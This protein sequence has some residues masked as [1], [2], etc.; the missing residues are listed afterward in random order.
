MDHIRILFP[1]GDEKRIDDEFQ[2][3]FGIIDK[4]FGGEYHTPEDMVVYFDMCSLLADNHIRLGNILEIGTYSQEWIQAYNDFSEKM[5]YT[6]QQKLSVTEAF[7]RL[8]S[9]IKSFLERKAKGEDG[10]KEEIQLANT[11][12]IRKQGCRCLLCRKR[13]ADK[14]GSHMAPQ[15]ILEKIFNINSKKGRDFEA[16]ERL[17]LGNE[18]R[19]EYFGSKVAPENR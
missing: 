11:P 10:V 15:L 9:R 19:Y 7:Q 16:V 18:E 8:I 13:I 1:L 6:E 5:R 3:L 14:T 4:T 12:N 17:D 2:K